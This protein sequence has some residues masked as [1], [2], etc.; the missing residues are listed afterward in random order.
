MFAQNKPN[1]LVVLADD[2]GLGDISH[3][4]KQHSNNIILQTPNLDALAKSGMIFNDAH[5]PAALCAPTR[6]A[7]MTGNHVFRSDAPWGVW[8]AYMP[9]AIKQED[10]TL[11]TLMKSAG[12]NTAFFGK[13]GI[14]SNFYRKDDATKIYRGN[15][16]KPEVDVD[17]TRI[18]SKG[19]KEHGFDYSL[20]FPSGIQDVPYAIYEN[21]V[22]LPFAADS[23]I[24]YISQEAMTKKGVKLDKSDGL[25]DTNWDPHHMG[26]L[27]TEKAIDYIERQ[28]S[29][30]PFFMYYCSLA[31]HLPH[32]PSKNM[33]NQDIAGTT[34][35][36]HLDMVKE[37]DIQMGMIIESLKRTG[38][39]ENTL[40]IF[41]SD[42]GGLLGK[43]TINSG[44]S[45][46]DIYR[47]GKNQPYEGGHRVPFIASWPGRIKPNSQSDIPVLGLDIL[48]TLAGLTDQKLDEH[49]AMDSSNLLPILMG[50]ENQTEPHPYL[51]TQGGTG[52]EVIIVKDGLKLIM[53]SD[54]QGIQREPIALFNLA[55]NPSERESE[56]LINK[57]SYKNK[58]E[59]LVN[60]YNNIR[61]NK[62]ATAVR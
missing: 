4:R 3:Y 42:N 31:V 16:S 5:A 50:T 48:A 36:K 39:Y 47:G 6:Y 57:P 13:W 17:I 28:D 21:E 58:I 54:L 37:L 22:W 24:G 26:P 29:N 27:I 43:P 23:E 45:S 61:D 46:S 8:G 25:G 49:E 60:A 51:M 34:P 35:S 33:N 11:G 38:L 56:N 1:V 12:Y 10:I 19:P 7:I 62:V 18:A 52:K 44:H 9:N 2:I 40:I 32:T 55:D 53:Q 20:M 30:K 14:G 15:R 41:T 59:Q